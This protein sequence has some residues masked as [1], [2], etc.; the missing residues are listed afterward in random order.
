MI[1]PGLYRGCELGRAPRGR[2]IVGD[3]VDGAGEGAPHAGM[4]HL[5]DVVHVAAR[6]VALPSPPLLRGARRSLRAA[7]REH[8]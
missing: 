6:R 7:V 8:L 1:V 2:V 4:E 3:V 5:P